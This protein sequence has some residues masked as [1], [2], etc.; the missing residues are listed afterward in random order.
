MSNASDVI[1]T[2]YSN[3]ETILSWLYLKQIVLFSELSP[4]LIEIAERCD[5]YYNTA[6]TKGEMLRLADEIRSIAEAMTNA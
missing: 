1:K 4:T 6:L 5:D 3:N 2:L